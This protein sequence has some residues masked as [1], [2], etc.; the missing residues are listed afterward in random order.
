MK[1]RYPYWIL[2]AFYVFLTA[3]LTYPLV[4]HL[5]T[6]VADTGDPLLNTWALAWGQHALRQPW[7]SIGDLFDTNAFYPYPQSL[8]FSE[9]LLPYAA[10]TLPLL[11]FKLGPIFSHNAAILFSLA[12]AGWGMA[13]LVTHW[14]GNRWAGLVAGMIFAFLPARLNHWAH[15]HQ[16]SIQWL[17][18]IILSLDRWLARKQWRDVALLGLFLNLQLLSAVNYVPQTIMLVGVYALVR[19]AYYV[20]RSAYQARQERAPQHATRDTRHVLRIAWGGLA[21]SAITLLV[22]WPIT[23]IYFDLSEIHG[24]ERNLGDASIYGAA[25][26]DYVTPPPENMLYGSWLTPRLA[27][28]ARPLIPLFI[29][30]VPMVLAVLAVIGAVAWSVGVLRKLRSRAGAP[31]LDSRPSRAAGFLLLL[32]VSAMLLSFGANEAALGRELAPL[33]SHLLFYR[34]LFEHVP[35]FSGLR[36]PARAAILAFFGLAALAGL[37]VASLYNARNAS[38]VKRIER[39]SEQAARIMRY[40]PIALILLIAVEYLALPLRG[41]RMPANETIPPVYRQLATQPEG[42]VVLELPYDLAKNGP[43]E[44]PRLYY[45]SYGW[46]R[47]V[48]GASG[49]NPQGLLDLSA[50]VQHFPDAVSFDVLRQ[51]GVTHLVLHSAEFTPDQWR[52]VWSRL[53]SFLP[54]VA[55][56]AQFG[57]DFLLTLRPPACSSPA[58]DIVLQ[59]RQVSGQLALSFSNQ[60]PA[61]YVSDPRATSRV[62]A[63]QINRRF[64]E[65]LFIP[66]GETRTL[67]KLAPLPGGYDGTVSLEVASLTFRGT[68]PVRDTTTSPPAG[69]GAA[70]PAQISLDVRFGD[71]GPRLVGYTLLARAGAACRVVTLRLYWAADAIPEAGTRSVVRLVDRFGQTMGLDTTYPWGNSSASNGVL[72]DDHRLS[73]PQTMPAGQY[74]AALGVL[75]GPGTAYRPLVK[76][77]LVASEREVLLSDLLVRPTAPA[78]ITSPAQP[79]GALANGVALLGY[80]IDKTQLAPGDWV[81]LTLF[82][83]AGDALSDNLTVFTQFS[84][85]GGRVWGQYDNPPGAGS[86]PTT[87]WQLGEVVSDDYL[88]HL[89]PATPAGELR[90]QVGLYHPDTLARIPA[91]DGAGNVSG[92][93][94]SVA[95][96]KVTAEGRSEAD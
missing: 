39:N 54:S 56:V 5:S 42:K 88:I 60:G 52:D 37:G 26:V 75:S 49:F 51:M 83:R 31:F 21:L 13:L 74:G 76:A 70:S 91:V 4:L 68:L 20:L 84:D 28:P 35:G 36:V 32:I 45:S 95:T 67:E 65:P 61:A 85:P 19:A 29:G 18:F 10:L 89:D 81:R 64:L 82:W 50:Q 73:I 25:L 40:V 71:A 77:N 90:L 27:D 79:V 6:Y 8:G 93:S 62:Q 41:T 57:D 30:F 38:W 22:N 9:H 94:I 96:L 1:Q 47:L 24:F 7:H 3:L 92:D 69:D 80:Q 44:L 58:G 43:R 34:W 48:N 59:P 12:L 15:L 86:Y 66:A 55:S 17:P 87:L 2:P 78:A 23:K 46:Y 33:T 11:A 53:P 14:T 63:G 16:L 72:I